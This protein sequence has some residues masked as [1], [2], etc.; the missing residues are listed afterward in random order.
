MQLITVDQ[1]G[2]NKKT[3]AEIRAELKLELT[4]IVGSSTFE[5][6]TISGELLNKFSEIMHNTAEVVV[7]QSWN[8]DIDTAEGMALERLANLFGL[9]R[10]EG[11]KTI[12]SIQITT[13]K[14]V[15]LQGGLFKVKDRN[16]NIYSLLDTVEN[17]SSGTH[18]LTFQADEVGV[19]NPL[20]NS[21][22]VIE[23]PIDGVISVNNL[24]APS[25]IGQAYET[26]DIFRARIKKSNSFNSLG[27]AS[28]LYAQLQ[29]IEGVTFAEVFVNNSNTVD[30]FG[31]N[32]YAVAC[33]VQGGSQNA[34][35]QAIANNIIGQ[36]TQGDTIGVAELA[37]GRQ[38][39]M[40]F[41]RPSP[42]ELYVKVDVYNIGEY[43]NLDFIKEAIINNTQFKVRQTASAD[44]IITNIKNNITQNV[45]I[46]EV[47]IS[48]DNITFAPFIAVNT[49]KE[50]LILKTDKINITVL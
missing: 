24:V 10:L 47:Q 43:A 40:E 17:L 7:S 11:F 39:A 41:S 49:F 14:I 19:L 33:V 3:L 23:T 16:Q 9:A 1:T 15:S 8:F 6:G 46:T 45:L 38:E 25:T 50:W 37:G 22:N 29:A 20:L 44:T 42:T 26:D 31:I 5:A 27:Y 18:T 2:I 21:V 30:A 4:Q 28:S 32:P 48:R 12:L 34:I 13:N 35:A 36:P